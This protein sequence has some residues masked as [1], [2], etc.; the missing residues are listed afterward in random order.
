MRVFSPI[1][2]RLIMNPFRTAVIDDQR[3]WKAG[4]L[5]IASLHLAREIER[6][7]DRD[8]VGV[9]LPSSGT[10]PLALIATWMLG[11][12]IVPLNFLLKEEERDYVI[13]DAELDTVV[14]VTPLIDMFGD[15]PDNINQIR[16]DKMQFKGFP[17]FR[18][19]KHQPDDFLATLLYTSGT[20]GKPKGVMLTSENLASNVE[21]C[22]EWAGFTKKDTLLGVLPQ[23]HSFGLTILT[24]LPLSV[25]CK[26]VYAAKFSP[27]QILKLLR[28]HQP[29]AF[30]GIPSMYNAL[31]HAKSAKPDDF[32][33]LRFIV[34]GGEPL[35]E[36]V[37]TGFKEKFGVTIN[38]GYGLT[39][40]GP[41]TNWC[42][43]Q[44]HKYKSVGQSVPRV[45]EKIVDENGKRLPPGEEGEICIKGPNIMPGYYK[46]PDETKAVFDDEGFFKTGDMG[47]FDEDGHLYITGR[48]KEMLIISGE[49]VFPREIEE[50]LNKHPSVNA[51]AVIG[52]PDE[53]R[54]EV[55]LAFV[56]LKEDAEFDAKDLRAHCRKHLAQY[57]VPR[58]I[59]WLDELPRNPTG[60]IMRKE[61]SADTP[62]LEKKKESEASGTAAG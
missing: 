3:Q 9:M 47:K 5:Y 26:V 27:T 35:P 59:R 39:E 43:P 45:E 49:N 4:M 55:P 25:G 17:P 21:Q 33:S 36:S 53:S 34:S 61:L 29:T 14:T 52:L 18:R 30:V 16:L 7:T 23:F 44:D 2:R 12:T 51:S 24:L 58:E 32:S 40:T 20:S 50:I 10:F 19:T 13:R 62:S 48:I 31:L 46:L 1:L 57:K 41:V 37:F 56:E 6:Q 15:L 22:V 38:E 28:K 11:R 42:R 8:K 54:G 60:K